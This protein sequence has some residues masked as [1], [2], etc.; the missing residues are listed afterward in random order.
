MPSLTIPFS[1]CGHEK[2]L[3]ISEAESPG[4]CFVGC[5]QCRCAHTT[6]DTG[7]THSSPTHPLGVWRQ[8]VSPQSETKVAGPTWDSCS[9]S[10]ELP[11][12]EV[13]ASPLRAEKHARFRLEN[14]IILAPGV[15]DTSS[16]FDSSPY[17]PVRRLSKAPKC[18]ET[19]S[20]R[21]R[22]SVAPLAQLANPSVRRTS[23]KG[24]PELSP[25]PPNNK[26][27]TSFPELG[28]LHRIC[29]VLSPTR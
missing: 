2:R 1:P 6:K 27:K 13:T 3:S 24:S 28:P 19:M 10:S 23:R 29:A 5:R 15:E 11:P 26:R 22:S 18:E 4:A 25:P 8:A 16:D 21:R 17:K 7:H 20:K 9:S 12:L 14:A